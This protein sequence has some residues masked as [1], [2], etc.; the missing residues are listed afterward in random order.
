MI[1]KRFIRLAGALVAP[2]LAVG[3]LVAQAGVA[4]AKA[5]WFSGNTLFVAPSGNQNN[6][7]TSC[8]SAGFSTIQSAVDAAPA[9]ATIIVCSG[10]YHEQVVISKPVTLTGRHA[11]IDQSG[12]TPTF[13]ITLPGLGSAQDT[14]ALQNT[15]NTLQDVVSML[16]DIV[17]KLPG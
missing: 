9:K 1:S 3:V 15:V 16:Q 7:G 11:T 6:N 10:T 13:T 17:S 14:A 12:V 2:A 5:S 8:H 4:S